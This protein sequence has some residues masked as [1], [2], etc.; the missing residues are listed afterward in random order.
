MLKITRQE[1]QDRGITLGLHGTLSGP[2]VVELSAA[3][4][5]VLAE[6]SRL[7][8]DLNGLA[9]L[10]AS[11]VSLLLALRERSVVLLNASRFVDELLKGDAP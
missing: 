11:G 10:D 9:F 8:L 2:W 5:G 7:S 6:R 3:S 4:D 1:D